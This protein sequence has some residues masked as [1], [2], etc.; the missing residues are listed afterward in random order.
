MH[1][2][3]VSYSCASFDAILLP[4]TVAEALTFVVKIGEKTYEY[5]Q[6]VNYQANSL[7]ICDI[8]VGNQVLTLHNIKTLLRND[9]AAQDNTIIGVDEPSLSYM[10]MRS[11]KQGKVMFGIGGTG[12]M[13]INW[14]DGV[15]EKYN[16]SGKK[17]Y[18]YTYSHDAAPRQINI[19][20]ENIHFFDCGKIDDNTNHLTDVDF[21]GNK[22]LKYL[23]V[24]HNKLTSLELGENTALE[25]LFCANNQITGIDLSNNTNLIELHISHNKLSTLHI[26]EIAGLEILC[27]DYNHFEELDIS[28]NTALLVLDCA[29]NKL[30]S[31][32]ISNNKS[33]IDLR[34]NN[35][36]IETLYLGAHKSLVRLFCQDNKFDVHG[37]NALFGSMHDKEL[38]QQKI[39]YIKGNPGTDGCDLNFAI[40]KRD[41]KSVV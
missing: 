18:E 21:S 38:E 33:F 7:Y 26:G 25:S 23:R 17:I 22:A 3:N 30:K 40:S 34:L 35:N 16:I 31:L 19:Y 10:T 36:L 28:K 24:I 29:G 9:K 5:R 20:G 12:Q 11:A 14:G 41:R 37:L 32:D 27:C 6:S 39:V 13:L 8:R 1:K 4:T 2:T 15:V